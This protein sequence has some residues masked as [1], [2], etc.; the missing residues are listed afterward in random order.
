MNRMIEKM[1][2]KYNPKSLDESI[3]ALREIFQQITLLALWRTNFYENAA[4]YGGT[5]LRILHNL[6]RYS[7][8]LDFSLLKPDK[9]FDISFFTDLIQKEINAYGFNV[10]VEKK[11]KK[12]S[13]NTESAFLKT[14]T[15]KKLLIIES[16]NKSSYK[17]PSNQILKIKIEI[18]INPP[19]GFNTEIKYL[20]EPIPFTV[21]VYSL[22]DLFAGKLHAVLCRKWQNRVKGRDWYDL[23][24][25]CINHPVVNLNHLRLRLIDSGHLKKESEFDLLILKKLLH[26]K[27]KEVNFDQ[28][29]LDIMPFIKNGEQVKLWNENLFLD[30][31]KR[32]KEQ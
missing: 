22:P 4:F 21:N 28:I 14:D 25:Y 26:E 12:F 11:Q 9:N 2:L 15:I 27:I 31:I 23:L 20:Y 30:V 6:D 19:G 32:V 13:S 16:L 5:A 17:I 18:D 24:W 1:I 10:T 29:K 8:D 3:N 7:E